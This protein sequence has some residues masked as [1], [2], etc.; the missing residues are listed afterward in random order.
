MDY[1]VGIDVVLH[2]PSPHYEDRNYMTLG[3]DLVTDL[4]LFRIPFPLSVGIRYIY[5]PETTVSMFQL[6]FAIDIR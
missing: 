5:E 1:M 4:N 6:L 2:D 3:G